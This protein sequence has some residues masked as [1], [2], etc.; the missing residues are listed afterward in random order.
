MTEWLTAISKF[1][2]DLGFP[3]V[4]SLWLMWFVSRVFVVNEIVK[5]LI[6]VDE[7]LERITLMLER[8][9]NDD[10]GSN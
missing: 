9:G 1:V 3:I 8:D 7:K 6:R 2:K 4:T 5:V 10:Q